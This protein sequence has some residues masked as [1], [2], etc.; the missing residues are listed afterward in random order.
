MKREILGFTSIY[1]IIKSGKNKQKEKKSETLKVI[2]ERI[3]FFLCFEFFL[4]II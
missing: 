4:M 1:K 2:L 3:L